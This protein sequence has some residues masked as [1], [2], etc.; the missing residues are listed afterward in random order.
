MEIKELV[1]ATGE[2]HNA[3]LGKTGSGKTSSAK[4]YVEELVRL[5]NR[6][7]CLDPIKADWW[8]VTSGVDGRSPGLPFQILGGQHGHVPVHEQAGPA[9]AKVVAT[10]ALPLSIV[11]M[12]DFGPGGISNFFT[13]F[14]P[15]LLQKM[16]GVLYLVLEEAHLFAPKERSG[17]GKENMSIHW[18]KQLALAG[19]STGIRLLVLTQRTQSLHNALLG[20][21]DT[22]YA[23]RLIAPADQDPVKKWLAGNT[24]K[25]RMEEV[26]ASLSQLSKGE[27]WVC[28]G[29]GIFEKVQFPRI[30]TYDNTATPT[31]NEARLP[32]NTAH[33]DVERLRLLIGDAVKEAQA[34]DPQLLRKQIA[35][36]QRENTALRDNLKPENE[37]IQHWQIDG[38]IY[39]EHTIREMERELER[40]RASERV[41]GQALR[42]AV[43][44]IE[45]YQAQMHTIRNAVTNRPPA[46]SAQGPVSMKM[47]EHIDPPS[48]EPILLPTPPARERGRSDIPPAGDNGGLKPM[49]R[50][51]LTVLAQRG[52]MTK[53]SLLLFAGYAS[54]GPVSSAFGFLNSSGYITSDGNKV[55]ITDAGRAALGPVTKLPRGAE[56]RAQTLNELP[57]MEAK[58]LKVW[59]DA[60]PQERTKG[61]VLKATGYASSGPVS[62]AFGKL[63][64][65]NF[66]VRGER[67]G[68]YLAS[69]EF[70]R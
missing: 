7:C 40:L 43:A 49:H 20:M 25:Q 13:G 11:D 69:A 44:Q 12:R 18:A 16:R 53:G 31:G 1:A 57:Q 33:V 48:G 34:N 62:S 52:A 36:L 65:R 19:R 26:T 21:C 29:D 28:S 64:R 37:R 8:G 4:V 23:H 2:G 17:I 3:F 70:F 38:K 45:F 41:D 9:V 27:C 6:V 56:L 67:S 42:D 10:G 66:I 51:F 58:L 46:G 35:E 22:I 50:K 15:V 61:E 68:S 30:K 54:S 24:T 59:F 14:A 39:H 55:S 5:G 63:N 60:Y 47:Y 32:V